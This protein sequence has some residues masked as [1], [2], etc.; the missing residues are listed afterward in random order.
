[1]CQLKTINAFIFKIKNMMQ[2]AFTPSVVSDYR[3][4]SRHSYYIRLFLLIPVFFLSVLANGQQNIQWVKGANT[5]SLNSESMSTTTDPFGNALF[6]GAFSAD[7][8]WFGD[9]PIKGKIGGRNIFILKVNPA[10]DIIW[11]QVITSRGLSIG[12]DIASDKSGNVYVTGYYV[13]QIDFEPGL[14]LV[15]TGSSSAFVTKLDSAGNYEW[16][17]SMD[18]MWGTTGLTGFT[19]GRYIAVNDSGDVFTFGEARYGIDFNPSNPGIDT[20][21]S[22]GSTGDWFLCKMDAKGDY[23]WN[24]HFEKT[25]GSLSG[26]HDGGLALDPAGNAYMMGSFSNSMEFP[27]SYNMPA[28]YSNGGYD[29][30]YIKANASGQLVWAKNFGG[31]SSDWGYSIKADKDYHLYLTGGFYRTVNFNPNTAGTPA[32]HSAHGTS[33][34]DAFVLKTDTA[35]NYVWANTFG[36]YKRTQGID[37]S[38]DYL[39]NVYVTGSFEDT[40][41]FVAGS[42]NPDD[43]ILSRGGYNYYLAKFDSTGKYIWS[44]SGGCR[45]N[46]PAASIGPDV[47]EDV[48]V[49]RFG[50]I[51]VTGTLRFQ[52]DTA[53]F[54]PRKE[55]GQFILTDKTK[56]SF[57]MKIGC[58]DTTSSVVEETAA[59]GVFVFNGVTYTESGSYVQRFTNAVGCDSTV[60]LKLTV[61]SMTKP[62]VTVNGFVLG[63][64]LRYNTYQWLLDNS[65]IAGATDSTYSVSANGN[66]SVVVTDEAGCVDTSDVYTVGNYTH[67]DETSILGHSIELYPNPTTG[68]IYI[69][70][71]VSIEVAVYSLEGKQLLKKQQADYL[72]ID[73]LSNGVYFL[74]VRDESGRLIKT[75]KF[76]KQ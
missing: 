8:F 24:V 17:K 38:L 73:H 15:S 27:A 23:L 71:P 52:S 9:T 54:S 1:M 19:T 22:I 3:S 35:G 31:S 59:C 70:S 42:T 18:G 66:Y 30:F 28:V 76:V 36:S 72:S 60:Y 56:Q 7:T 32:M 29:I 48:T 14:R 44:R 37:L 49:D 5:V 46:P 65:P 67:I 12:Y 58:T 16:A 33:F 62:V 26:G 40:V 21:H 47:G 10:G 68:K 39:G 64:Q 13:K 69:K 53:D 57:I 55:P 20:F 50:N 6:T 43:M 45:N 75:E 34:P 11:S 4:L 41:T 61:N 63:V 2:T 74:Q 25:L 51:Y